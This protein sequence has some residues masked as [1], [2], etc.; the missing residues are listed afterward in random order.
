MPKITHLQYCN[1]DPVITI[2]LFTEKTFPTSVIKVFVA[3]FVLELLNSFLRREEAFSFPMEE[4]RKW[5]T[6]NIH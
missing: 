4:S 1:T 5:W 3:D 2:C 6:V